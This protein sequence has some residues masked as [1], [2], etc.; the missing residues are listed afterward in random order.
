MKLT[1]EILKD[2]FAGSLEAVSVSGDSR[3]RFKDVRLPVPDEDYEPDYLYLMSAKNYERAAGRVNAIVAE[4]TSMQ[5]AEGYCLIEA[6]CETGS[7]FNLVRS[8]FTEYAEHFEFLYASI[9]KGENIEAILEKAFPLLGN[10]PIFIDDSSYRTLAR[11][12][13]YPTQD[14]RDN[15]YIFMQQNGHHSADYIYAM[16]N[17]NVAVESSAISPKPIVHR[18]DFLSHR[19]LYS[20]IKVDREIV[21]FFSCLE[22]VQSITP[23]MMDV[24]ESLTELWS[25]TL[26]RQQSLS[27]SRQKSLDNDLFLGILN[28]SIVDSE[29]TRT[30]FAQVGLTQGDYF[31]VYAATNVD[32]EANP[33][34]LPRIL[35]LLRT[36]LD[37]FPVADG[38]GIVLVLNRR[39]EDELRENLVSLINFYLGG[40]NVIIGISLGFKDPTLLPVYFDQALTATR[41]GPLTGQVREGRQVYGYERV[42]GY[43][44]LE[45]FGNREKRLCLCH[46]AVFVLLEHDREKKMNLLPTLKM[47]I[48]CMG[49]T[50]QAAEKL[51]LH[52]NSLYYRL[53]QIIT[54]T[55][56]DL[57]DEH[58][59]SHISLS[60]RVLEIN[61]DIL[62]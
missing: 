39:L 20:T 48:E 27:A 58:V 62:P 14:F 38:A 25:V 29:L 1:P 42:V 40:F 59:L 11:L 16:L 21:G 19:T 28:G 49:D 7:L 47:F 26:T 30:A 36:N 33:F 12:K 22:L 6:P 10:N 41:L 53:K 24:F 52:R 9:A 55:G 13:D 56:L 60:L 17:S 44:V 3:R 18:F 45:R 35:E 31:V 46:P 57:E 54:L 8:C 37:C 43:D 51:Y 34:L 2:Y 15:E 5:P 61:G 50:A 32:I 4:A 23:G